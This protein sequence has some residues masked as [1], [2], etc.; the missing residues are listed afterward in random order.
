MNKK[1]FYIITTC[2]LVAAVIA[3]QIVMYYIVGEETLLKKWKNTFPLAFFPHC[4]P[5]FV[6][7]AGFYYQKIQQYG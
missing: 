6:F 1:K 2:C 7:P 5:V 3:F 4:F